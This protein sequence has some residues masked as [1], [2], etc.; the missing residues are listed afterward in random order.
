MKKFIS[1]ALALVMA[2]S[3][4]TV[5]DAPKAD[6]AFT[7]ADE[8]SSQYAEQAADV[9]QV[10]EVMD[11]YDDGT[12]RPTAGL[13]RQ[14][15]AKIICNMILGP[16][17]A[18]ALPTNAN[19]FPDVLAGNQFSGYVSYCAQQGIISG[20]AD[21]T[22]RGGDPLSGY[23]YLKMLLGA[24]GYSATEEGF[25]GDNWKVNVAKIALGIGLNKG[26]EED[27]DG[28]T[29]V[30]REAAAIYAFNTIQADMVEYDARNSIEI[31]GVTVSM[32]GGNATPQTW[33]TSSTS[34]NNINGR[35]SDGNNARPIVQFAERYFDKLRREPNM[36]DT[37][38]QDDF[39]RPSIRWFW[40]GVEV[41]TYSRDPDATFVGGVDVNRIYEELGM[42]SADDSADL[43]INSD[44]PNNAR[45]NVARSNDKG[46]GDFVLKDGNGNSSNVYGD[47]N[48]RVDRIGDGTLIECYRNDANNHVDVCVI[49]VYGGKVSS[50]K[51]ATTKKDAYV[52]IDWANDAAHRPDTI[53]RANSGNNEFETEDFDE[54]DVVAYTYSDSA[55]E[56]KSMYLMTS[57]SG[58]LQSRVS[59]KSLTLDSTRY[60]YGKEYS[61]HDIP[62]NENGLSN[63]SSYIVYL[64]D[65]E[66]VLWVE[67]DEFAVDQYVLIERIRI[68][69]SI[70]NANGTVEQTTTASVIGGNNAPGD[71]DTVLNSSTLQMLYQQ[72]KSPLGN[73][74]WDADARV[75]YANGT[76]RTITLDDSKNYRTS[77]SNDVTTQTTLANYRWNSGLATPRLEKTTDG[78]ATWAATSDTYA[79]YNNGANTGK[80][81]WIATPFTAGHIVRV[82]STS[83]G[84]KLHSLND[85][86][87]LTVDKFFISGKS[88]RTGGSRADTDNNITF[89]LNGQR[90]VLNADS[91]THF[92]IDDTANGT[93][94]TYVGI[95]NAPDV[96]AY[97]ANAQRDAVAYIYHR[98]GVAKLVFVT[99][100]ATVS[101]SSNDIIFLAANSTSN[102][103]DSDIDQYYDISAVDKN[104]IKTLRIRRGLDSPLTM[105]GIS[106]TPGAGHDDELHCVILNNVT[107]DS[108]DL[109]TSGSF[110]SGASNRLR[111]D[112]AQGIRR[113]NDEEIRINTHFSNSIL[114]DVAE[115]IRV[116]FVDGDDIEQ[117]DVDEIVSD[118]G[119]MVYYVEDDGEITYLFIVDYDGDAEIEETTTYYADGEL[120][121]SGNTE[122]FVFHY[123]DD[124][125]KARVRDALRGFLGVPNDTTAQVTDIDGGYN[126]RI[127]GVDYTVMLE[128]NGR[129]PVTANW[130]TVTG[131]S[132]QQMFSRS[133]NRYSIDTSVDP[134]VVVNSN[135]GCIPGMPL[136][137]V[138]TLGGGVTTVSVTLTELDANNNATNT[139]TVNAEAT[140]VSGQM[141]ATFTVPSANF[142]LSIDGR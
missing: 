136:N 83:S 95:R 1:M 61:F 21:G 75:R 64:D 138:M 19:P 37:Y 4:C 122:N 22:F 107:Y 11:G 16:T 79:G 42:T 97:T 106:F 43:Y 25:V 74:T 47:G 73:S 98:D 26:I 67:E 59:G 12:F 132:N 117:I 60:N 6:A 20:Y 54:D 49:S 102:L 82:S 80:G 5:F 127:D 130:G 23:A 41:G 116:Y 118:T 53:S 65:N 40:K 90:R 78:G 34:A 68:E 2:L 10:I 96:D 105:S 101:S 9:I 142:T 58:V 66:Y 104:E 48:H 103:I 63:K 139:T 56:I 84:Y 71:V 123:L 100:T 133:Y 29:Q 35:T 50:V 113:V 88:I 32:G 70:T 124:A 87:V 125:G 85:S 86:Q 115:N 33:N 131:V 55:Q 108:N 114:K 52:T 126:I 134:H 81:N 110:N 137:V 17:T 46:L 129:A 30:T 57:E 62:N 38:T 111:A 112:Q 39:G 27:L 72:T 36:W 45:L 92:A 3:L 13:T 7:D 15:A 109:I 140:N 99:R 141:Q 93:Y 28:T 69:T 135:N 77:A 121:R 76:V 51:G 24:L 91:E 8:L 128:K 44:T 31:N 94:R 14:A 18:R 119:D 89:T 120:V